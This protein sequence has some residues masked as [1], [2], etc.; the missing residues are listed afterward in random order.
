[1]VLVVSE[2]NSSRQVMGKRCTYRLAIV[3][4]VTEFLSRNEKAR[5]PRSVRGNSR[6]DG[7]P[8]G[9]NN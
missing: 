5:M 9:L 7:G 1:M 2:G 3:G 8:Y 4:I 6:R